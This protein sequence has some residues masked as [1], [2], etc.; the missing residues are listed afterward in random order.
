MSSSPELDRA[1][2]ALYDRV[3]CELLEYTWQLE[4]LRVALAAAGDDPVAM[5]RA[6][7]RCLVAGRLTA[8]PLTRGV[9][10]RRAVEPG[11]P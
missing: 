7:T 5:E 2:G 4:T 6:V 11:Q 9:L 3:H 10:N 1:V 8:S